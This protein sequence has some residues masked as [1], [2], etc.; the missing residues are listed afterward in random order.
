V[1]TGEVGGMGGGL[2]AG[3]GGGGGACGSYFLG[4]WDAEATGLVLKLRARAGRHRE[5]ARVSRKRQAR[6]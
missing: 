5:N 1:G 2:G 4:F 6:L 3:G